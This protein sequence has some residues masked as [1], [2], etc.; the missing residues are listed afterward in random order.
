MPTVRPSGMSPNPSPTLVPPLLSITPHI[1][2]YQNL[3]A[4]HPHPATAPERTS[5]TAPRNPAVPKPHIVN[6][7]FHSAQTPT[8]LSSPLHP[9]L[10]HK[11]HIIASRAVPPPHTHPPTARSA[12]RTQ[13]RATPPHPIPSPSHLPPT[14]SLPTQPANSVSSPSSGPPRL[15]IP[16]PPRKLSW[17]L[18]TERKKKRNHYLGNRCMRMLLR[19][20]REVGGRRRGR[21][22]GE[23]WCAGR[24]VSITG[25]TR[26][27]IVRRP[28]G[29]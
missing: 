25:Y 22:Y 18:H 7:S 27:P 4:T 11:H 10:Q 15:T 5:T 23:V 12:Y 9:N 26:G 28:R 17:T 1:R 19:D 6:P 3:H 24:W 21:G 16:T 29:R 14:H 20:P 13:T 2:R 8:S